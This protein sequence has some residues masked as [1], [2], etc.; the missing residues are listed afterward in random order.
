MRTGM[1]ALGLGLL[2]VR[3]L[4]ALPPVGW[5]YVL[6]ALAL[7]L[8]WRLYGVMLFTVGLAWS[9]ISAQS[10]LDDRLDRAL[11]GQTRWLE[12]RVVGLPQ[13]AHGRVRFMLEDIRSRHQGLPT[14]IRVTWHDGPPVRNGERWRLAVRLK[15][16]SGLVNPGGFDQ[17]AWLLAR[18]IGATGTVVDGQRLVA[19]EP[20]WRDSIRERL[21]EV[22]A[23]GHNGLL[24][25]LVLG[26]QS[27]LTQAQW[28][29]LQV[30]GT[31]HLLVISGT[32]VGL[33]AGLLY[34]AVVFAVRRGVWPMRVPWLPVACVLALGGALGYGVLAGFEV[35]VR[36]ACLM[37]GMV[38]LWRLRY[39]HLGAGR[40]LLAAWVLVLLGDPLASLQPG[41]W[42]SFAAVAI[43]LLVFAGRL[44]AWRW[45]RSW[46]RAQWCVALGLVP[47]MIALGLPVSISGPLVNL[48]AVPWLSTVTL[49]LALAGTALLG[50]PVLGEPL[51]WLAGGA[52]GLMFEGLRLAADV[53]PVWVP[54]APPLWVWMIG[55]AGVLLYLLPGGMPLRLPGA[56]LVLLLAWPPKEE[57]PVGQAHVLQLD[58]GQGLAILIRTRHHTLL[59]DAGPRARDFDAG[60]QIVLPALRREGV[61]VLDRLLLSHADADH[62]GGAAAII[63]GMPVGDLLAGDSGRLP[64]QLSARPCQ[65]GE[66]WQWDG[67]SF[68]TWY[69]LEAPPGNAASCVLRVEAGGEAMVLTGDIDSSVERALLDDPPFPLA[70]E[71]LQA[72]HHGSRTSSSAPFLRAVAPRGVLLSRGLNNAFGH[73]H[74]LV[75]ARYRGLGIEV[76]DSAEQGALTLRLGR[77]EEPRP[78]PEHRRFWRD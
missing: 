49:P 73:P 13:T 40:P 61:V 74:P 66:A 9:G 64:A 35:P 31:V 76:W 10:A 8:P 27:G 71:W 23:Q 21:L 25:A 67:V 12:G 20:G 62:A 28:R 14:R 6:P 77:F 33:L 41:F 32:H 60:E 46:G 26:D 75:M 44:G 68:T 37:V 63:G 2:A 24:A 15:R 18:R 48:L 34:G 50:A 55:T 47:L 36:R 16:P 78:I 57:I 22:D 70:A 65:A 59:Y 7:L 42:L 43:L 52:L 3:F 19:V 56:L 45:L 1:V 53:I 11:S 39:R 72:P 38:L 58:V 29:T 5:W 69:H 54:V 30:T 17:Q 51:L 4:P